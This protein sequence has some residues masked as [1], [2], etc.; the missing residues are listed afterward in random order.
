MSTSSAGP[1]AFTGGASTT[2][3][4]ASTTTPMQSTN[5]SDSGLAAGLGAG[6]GVGLSL[7]AAAILACF[8]YGRRRA[9]PVAVPEMQPHPAPL[10]YQDQQAKDNIHIQSEPVELEIERPPQELHAGSSS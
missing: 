8:I 9:R 10:F 1:T 3:S 2:G 5:S 4:S 7:I 6:L